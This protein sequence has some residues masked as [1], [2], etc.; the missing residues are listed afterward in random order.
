MTRLAHTIS[1]RQTW[2]RANLP[3]RVELLRSKALGWFESR[4]QLMALLLA[5]PVCPSLGILSCWL[6]LQGSSMHLDFHQNIFVEHNAWPPDASSLP[7]YMNASSY[8]LFANIFILL[9]V[10]ILYPLSGVRQL[11]R[12]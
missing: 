10:G 5:L 8:L 7:F 2:E 6:L 1:A 9:F 4:D 3:G 12:I 11:S